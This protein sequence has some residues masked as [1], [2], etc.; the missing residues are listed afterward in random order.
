VIIW[1]VRNEDKGKHKKFDHLW[2]GPLRIDMYCEN[3]AYFLEGINGE[4]LGWGPVNGRFLN[5]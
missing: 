1:D 4:C 5:H 3:N 2:I